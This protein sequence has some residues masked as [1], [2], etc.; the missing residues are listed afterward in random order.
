[1]DRVRDSH[2]I[3]NIYVNTDH[4]FYIADVRDAHTLH[5][6]FEKE[7]PDIVIHGAAESKD[8]ASMVSSN[9][10]GTQNIINECMKID[11]R[12]VYVSDNNIYGELKSE[13]DSPYNELDTPNPRGTFAATKAAGELLVK[14]SSFYGLSGLHYNIVRLSDNYGPWQTA[15]NLIPRI[16]DCIL[17]DRYISEENIN[18]NDSGAHTKE[19]THVFDTCS[20]LFS[21]IDNGVDREIYNIT[22]KQEFSNLE[23]V[24]MICNTIGK[25]HE[26]IKHV[27]SNFDRRLAMSNDKIKTLGWNPQFKFRDG[28]AQ[29]CQWYVSNKYVLN[30]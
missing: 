18:I 3:H 10:V 2:I 9:L 27:E 14:A 29:T 30:M 20:A 11:A 7:R 19:W 16:I 22:S 15:S 28:I 23:V 26:L 21:I 4:S 8:E 1:M 25:G 6:I 12:L 17:N 24:Q 5:V 13:N